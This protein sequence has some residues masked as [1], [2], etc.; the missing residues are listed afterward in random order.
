MSYYAE[1]EKNETNKVW[2]KF[3]KQE[4]TQRGLT[5][6]SV[7]ITS[8]NDES[9]KN[10]GVTVNDTKN[11]EDKYYGEDNKTFDNDKKYFNPNSNTNPTQ[12]NDWLPIL[13][14]FAAIIIIPPFFT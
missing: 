8:I 2:D 4:L 13:L 1:A 3:D 14:G 12:S 9:K 10:I 6:R 5:A 11:I 7:N